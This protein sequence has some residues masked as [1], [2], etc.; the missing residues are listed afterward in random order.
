M[1]EYLKILSRPDRPKIGVVVSSGGLKSMS[2]FELFDFLEDAQIPID[3]LAGCSGGSM[4]T[5]LKAIGF[6]SDQMRQK[7]KALL[8]PELFK[9]NYKT[10]AAFV[11]IPFF[12]HKK[13]QGI[14]RSENLLKALKIAFGE[15]TKIEDLKIPLILQ[16]TD[17]DTGLAQLLTT[18]N[19]AN[20]VYASSALLPFFPPIEINGQ[21]LADGGYS[22][23]MPLL[24]LVMKGVDVIIAVDVQPKASYLKKNTGKGS[25]YI[26]H[27]ENFFMMTLSNSSS[28]QKTLAVDMHHHEIIFIE[29]PFEEPVELWDVD[30][31][32]MIEKKGRDAVEKV[33]DQII[34]AI[35]TFR[36]M[37]SK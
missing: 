2:S 12:T 3:L 20:A 33:K 5:S 13:D 19:L 1:E 10:L 31:L 21:W 23:P 9:I 11:K 36:P 17:V 18:G 24:P 30:K 35:E 28:F 25:S 29:I 8:S 34:W 32:P 6:T 7:L 14:L 37:S 26:Q 27:F 4:C 22:S 16:T 15:T